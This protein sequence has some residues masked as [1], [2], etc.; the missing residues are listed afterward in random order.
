M[1]RALAR[2]FGVHR[3]EVRAALECAVPVPRKVSGRP[4]PKLGEFKP[5]IDGWLEADL[6]LPRKQRHTARRVWQR[7]VVEHGADVGESTVRR[8]VREVRE[9]Q[10]VPLVDVAVPQNKEFQ[11]T[12]RRK[13][14]I[15]YNA[16]FWR[17]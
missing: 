3:R 2:R 15:K 10:S 4:S 9:R 6:K 14:T 8:Y 7:L 11:P 13:R 16:L 17:R 12:C 5:V 1:I